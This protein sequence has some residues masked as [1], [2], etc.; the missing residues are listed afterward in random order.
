M[1]CLYSSTYIIRYCKANCNSDFC[2][3]FSSNLHTPNKVF[4]LLKMQ[5]TVFCDC[6]WLDKLVFWLF[7]ILRGDD[8]NDNR[9]HRN[10]DGRHLLL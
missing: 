10:D 3:I 2:T 5:K 7:S 1:I 4:S 9:D 6:F 8:D